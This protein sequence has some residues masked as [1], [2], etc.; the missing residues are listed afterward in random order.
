MADQPTSEEREE[1]QLVGEAPSPADELFPL[2]VA[3]GIAHC[4]RKAERD[5][6]VRNVLDVRHTWLWGRRRMGKTSLVEQVVEDLDRRGSNVAVE[7]IDLLVM[8]DAED[9]EAQLLKAVARLGVAIAPRAPSSASR[10]GTAFSALKPEFSVGA[11]GLSMKL[12]SPGRESQGIVEAIRGLDEAAGAHNRRA[13]LVLD[14][15]QQL[16]A[17]KDSANLEGA[18]R[19]AVER[20]RHVTCVFAGSQRHLLA[21]MFEREDRPLFRL[22]RKMTL[23]RIAAAEYLDFMREASARRWGEE[24]G[25]AAVERILDATMRHPYYVNA[26]CSRLWGGAAPPNASAV[27]AAWE[28]IALEDKPMAAARILGLAG[29]QRALLSAIANEPDGVEHP[30]SHDFLGPIRL[31][32]STGN[33]AKEVLEQEDLIRRDNDGRWRLIDPAMSFCLRRL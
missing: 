9:F 3:K 27:D 8:H 15:F 17:I 18:V 21:P 32:T 28:R 31:A 1:Q 22:C 14:E 20:V 24:L 23:G 13:L 10:L 6:L 33:R 19:H 29:S 16:T 11:P 5:E 4:N 30:T 12:R 2:G 7:T 25:D 26:L